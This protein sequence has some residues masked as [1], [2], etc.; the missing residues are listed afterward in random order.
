[1]NFKTTMKAT[2]LI[3]L[4]IITGIISLPVAAADYVIHAGRLI[5]GV[6]KKVQE[7]V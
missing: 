2:L 1:M 7:S 4:T 3:V 5:D 6:S